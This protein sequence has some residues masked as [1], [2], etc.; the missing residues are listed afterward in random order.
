MYDI[1]SHNDDDDDNDDDNDDDDKN[2]AH[3]LLPVFFGA[4]F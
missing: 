4:L 3:Y 2:K 1:L